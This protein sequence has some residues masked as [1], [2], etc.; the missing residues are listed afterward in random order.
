[1][2]QGD[3]AMGFPRSLAGILRTL[4]AQN[5]GVAAIEF[6]F[7]SMA[8]LTLVAGTVD[9]GTLLYTESQID[10]AVAAGA[11]YA[12][13][14]AAGVNSTNGAS[15]A[16]TI[17]NIVANTNGSNWA[18]SGVCVNNGPSATVGGSAPN[19]S[20]VAAGADDSYCPTGSPPNWSW[21]SSLTAGS[22][23]GAGGGIAGKFVA[24]TASRNFT[25]LFPAFGFVPSG[26]ISQSALVETE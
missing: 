3:G 10:A 22:A 15:L 25:P 14:N 18:S 5:S 9:I 1:M 17:A 16:S 2:R 13:V 8:F 7:V 23:C 12:A 20:G 21:G 11:E 19:C 26:T 24:I 6:A 4:R